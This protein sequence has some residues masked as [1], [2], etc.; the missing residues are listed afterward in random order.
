MENRGNSSQDSYPGMGHRGFNA[1]GNRAGQAGV[2]CDHLSNASL[3]LMAGPSFRALDEEAGS[4]IS[5]TC[6]VMVLTVQID[7][8]V[9]TR[10]GKRCILTLMGRVSVARKPILVRGH[11]PIMALG[12]LRVEGRSTNLTRIQSRGVGK[13]SLIRILMCW[14]C[15]NSR[16]LLW[17]CC[18]S[19]W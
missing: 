1:G 8:K 11:S 18:S 13:S 4:L 3:Q 14:T 6:M 17:H 10:D 12:E 16:C 2:L 9:I 5:V 19:C 15:L 7:S